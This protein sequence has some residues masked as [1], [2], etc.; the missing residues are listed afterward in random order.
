MEDTTRLT[1]PEDDRR[2]ENQKGDG[3]RRVS[4]TVGPGSSKQ[5]F[6]D[7]ECS[8]DSGCSSGGSTGSAERLS[9]RGS[10]ERLCRATRSPR[11]HCYLDRLRGRPT[12]SQERLSSIQRSSERV[13]AKSSRSW[14]PGDVRG[15]GRTSES[16]SYS[17]SPS[18]AH[19]STD[20]DSLKRSSTADTLR[21]ALQTLKISS[22]WEGKENKH[23]KKSPK[24]ILRS[25][26]SYTYV[27][28]LSGLP[29][30]R[31][32]RNMAQQLTMPC[33]CQDTVGLYR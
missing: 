18:D 24:R 3:K 13:R 27:R 11:T 15:V 22:K 26:V 20:S 23:A 21:R 30:Q 33:S 4:P 32:P 5:E 2:R 12:R 19:S 25:P 6:G 16:L 17:S 31:V 8:T 7:D 28:G 9:R 1:D 29:T 14:S 10:S